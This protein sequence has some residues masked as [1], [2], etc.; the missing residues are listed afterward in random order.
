MDEFSNVLRDGIDYK[1]H[2]GQDRLAE[3]ERG[4]VKNNM[5]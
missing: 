1:R 2:F 4:L 3:G 5:A